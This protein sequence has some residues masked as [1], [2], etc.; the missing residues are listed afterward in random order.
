MKLGLLDAVPPEFYLVDEKTDPDKFRDLFAAVGVTEALLHYEVTVGRYPDAL[1]E[2][3]A[4]LITGSPCSVYDELSWIHDLEN[5]IRQCYN[6]GKPLVGICFGHQLI[7]QALGGKVQQAEQGWVL[8][9][10]NLNIRQ[11]KSWMI[12]F[13]A[14]CSLYFI[15]QDQVVELPPTAEWVG[16]NNLCPHAMFTLGDKVLCLQAHPEQPVTS[17]RAFTEYLKSKLPDEIYQQAQA[18]FAAGTPDATLFGSWIWQF[19][20]KARG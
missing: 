19:L 12:P 2:C 15:N 20:E 1:D 17:M 5:F 9:L 8:G 3:E 7:A 6:A 10:Q 11:T 14:D 13:Q 18:S 16:Q 4:Y